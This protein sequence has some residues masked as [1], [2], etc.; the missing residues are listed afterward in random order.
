MA[1]Y[2]FSWVLEGKLAGMAVPDGLK[3]D[4]DELKGRGVGAV[5]NLTQ[6]DRFGRSIREAGLEYAQFPI[7]NFQPP[8]REQ[9]EEFVEFCDGQ[10]ER[11]NGVV[12]H[13][14][15]GMGRTGAM[16]ACYMV[17]SGM[18]PGE[19]IEKIRRLRPGSIETDEQENA[20]FEFAAR[21][22]D[23]AG[24]VPSVERNRRDK[25]K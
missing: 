15:A 23:C 21:L 14:L 9:V 1:L 3:E 22:R 12:V 20:V 5:V 19:A 6:G 11:G 8:T 13:C 7:E 17:R 24:P 25:L 10:I 18:A 4:W 16:L 2:E